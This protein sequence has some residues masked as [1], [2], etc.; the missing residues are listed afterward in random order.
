MADGTRQTTELGWR[1]QWAQWIMAL[2]VMVAFVLRV[3]R[4]GTQ[5]L[6]GDQAFGYFLSLKTLPD[7][8]RSTI[9]LQEPHPVASYFL[10]HAWLALAGHSEVALRFVSAWFGVLAVALLY[11]LGRR[12][13]LG[14]V[15][16]TLAAGLMAAS[17]YAIWHSQDARM[18]T[19]SLALTTAS[20]W[21][22]IEATQRRHWKFLV[23][24][25]GVTWLALQTHYFAF[26]IVIAQNLFFFGT[27]LVDKELRRSVGRWLF[28]QVVLG[29]LYLPWLLVA[30]DTLAGYRGNGDSPGFAAMLQRALSVFA[31]GETIPV[32]QRLGIAILAG[33]LLLIGGVRLALAGPR[34]RRALALLGLY[35]AV[36]LLATWLSALQRPIFNERYLVAAAPPFYLLL[37]AA[38]FGASGT[39]ART[40]RRIGGLGWVAAALLLLVMFGAF[41]SL[42]QYYTSPFPGRAYGWRELAATLKRYSAALP[43]DQVRLVENVPDPTLWYYYRGPVDHLVLPPRR[44]DEAETT[45]EVERLVSEGVQRIVIAIQPVEWWDP[46]GMAERVLDQH[47]TLAATSQVAYWPVQV[48]VRP[49]T[50]LS[51]VDEVFFAPAQA[52]NTSAGVRLAAAGIPARQL[53][54]GDVLDVHLKWEGAAQALS[55]TE[56]ITLQ[57]LDSAGQ[58]V[59][60]TDQPLRAAD[61]KAPGSSYMVPIPGQLS[62]GDYTLIA[63]LYDPAQPG[64]PRW[65]NAAGSDHVLLAVLP[66]QS[67]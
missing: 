17:P 21:L 54:A 22:A 60:Q 50:A 3:F 25:V 48:Y 44:N 15:T 64:A 7:I 12:L 58:L 24:Y 55:G 49:P 5:E 27:M 28:T 41:S 2:V 1:A 42:V 46:T 14:A 59:A 13:G 34:A 26:F 9:A 56:K 62:P 35:L 29:L 10:Q 38:V 53:I 36:P 23:A 16:A 47:Y 52:G 33:A 65:L 43:P 20:T 57:L 4:L 40:Q 18:Y 31:A 30:A 11:R 51:A 61:L 67:P 63:A 8:I 37:S 39:P 32:E 6:R 45:Q 66:M 19:I